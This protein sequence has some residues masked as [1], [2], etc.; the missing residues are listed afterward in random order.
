MPRTTPL[1]RMRNI[2]IAAHIDAGKTTTT[3][4]I[5]YYTGRTHKLGE[6]HEGTATMDW[7]E[8]EQ[9]RGI[10]IT[11]AAT[12]CEWRDIQINIIDTPGH[13]DFTAEVERSLRVLDGAVAVFDAVAGVQPQSETVWRQADKYS[14]PRICFINKMDRVGADFYHSVETIVDRLKCRPVPIQLPIG[15]EE[16]FLG[17]IDLVTMKARVWLDETL[18]AEFNEIEIPEDQAAEAKQYHD[19]L[20][21]AAAEFDDHLFA[22]F[23]EGQP[24]TEL[25]LRAGIRKATI[26]QKIFPVVCA[27]AFKNKGVQNLLDAVVA[28]LPS[29]LDVPPIQGVDLHDKEKILVRRPDDKEPFSALVFKIM[30]DPFVGQ[31]AFIRVYSGRL[32]AGES[33]FNV[34]KGRKERIGRIVKMHA[35]KREE[36]QEVLAGDIAAAVGLK[37]VSTGDTICDDRSPVV[38]E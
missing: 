31:L 20:V 38:L 15:A 8:Q 17:I 32:V 18:G 34:A 1:E 3:E 23:I 37:S 7:M 25:E 36:V 4:R 16:K 9:E 14:V 21:E 10:T 12:T 30:T 5:L 27:T 11:S 24:I 19:Q 26:A 28:Y 29:P 22:K 33:V 35:N 13:V 2:G 6:V